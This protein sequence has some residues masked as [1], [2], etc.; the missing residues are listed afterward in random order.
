MCRVSTRSFG[1]VEDAVLRWRRAAVERCCHV[2]SSVALSVGGVVWLGVG[3]FFCVVL[4]YSGEY[5][6][7]AKAYKQK[8]NKVDCKG[9]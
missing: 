4:I 1:H 6:F 8:Q 9:H 5:V 7:E 2:L 3:G